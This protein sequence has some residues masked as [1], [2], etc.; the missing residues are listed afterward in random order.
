MTNAIWSFLNLLFNKGYY[1][2][3]RLMCMK[4][5]YTSFEEFKKDL[6]KEFTFKDLAIITNA[7]DEK[8]FVGQMVCCK[9]H[10]EKTPSMQI[11][12]H[13]YRCYGCG[14]RGDIF[15]FLERLNNYSFIEA[16]NDVADAVKTTITVRTGYNS[17]AIKSKKITISKEWETFKNDYMIACQ[18][19]NK[20][21]M[22]EG[23]R[24]FPF[25][26]GYDKAENRIVLPFIKNEQ[27]LG[28][29][30][31][32]VGDGLPKWKHSNG[33]KYLTFLVS[34]IFNIDSI[35]NK[36]DVYIVEGPGDVASMIR[37]GYDNTVCCCG[38]SNISSQVLERLTAERVESIHFMPD[39]DDAGIKARL[40]WCFALIK[41][42]YYLASNSD[43]AI[44]SDKNDDPGIC[45]KEKLNKYINNSMNV[46]DYFISNISN[47]DIFEAFKDKSFITNNPIRKLMIQEFADRENLEYTDAK[48][49]I[50]KHTPNNNYKSSDNEYLCRLKATAGIGD[51]GLKFDPIEGMS[52]SKALRIIKLKFKGEV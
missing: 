31:R 24:Y 33:E 6:N 46:I 39:G 49:I 1:I 14:N 7:I 34:Q 17:D 41:Y 32:I 37:A 40:K 48:S 29:T 30:E 50:I 9:F 36:K 19:K 42:D 27:V 5:N 18:S 43:V 13:F 20:D 28:F 8:E 26:V 23:Q 45:T 10:K 16:V 25:D 15:T 11:G 12:D 2:T 21:V 44:I 52:S 4:D 35:K 3:W 47:K 51:F 38:T 22:K